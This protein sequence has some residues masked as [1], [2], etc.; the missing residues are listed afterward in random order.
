MIYFIAE[1]QQ[2]IQEI[3]DPPKWQIVTVPSIPVANNNQ[4]MSQSIN[5]MSFDDDG[6]KQRVRRVACSCPNC[7]ETDRNLRYGSMRWMNIQ[8][9]M[10]C[11]ML[12]AISLLQGWRREST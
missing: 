7:I 3:V 12:H 9:F 2:Q 4:N 8:F 6:P 11:V 10:K 5:E 1:T